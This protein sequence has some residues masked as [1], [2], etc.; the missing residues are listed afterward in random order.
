MSAMEKPN[1]LDGLTFVDYVGTWRNDG[2]DANPTA[3]Q[4]LEPEVMIERLF[5]MLQDYT[6]D[7]TFEKYGDFLQRNPKLLDGRTGDYVHLFGNFYDYSFVFNLETKNENL[8]ARFAKAVAEN[9]KK[10]SYVEAKAIREDQDARKAA[11]Y[12][13][14]GHTQ[15]ARA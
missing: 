5:L 13:N 12:R 15:S 3:P 1:T 11:Y 2:S 4:G 9:K 6:L 10:A 7:P 8:V 14:I